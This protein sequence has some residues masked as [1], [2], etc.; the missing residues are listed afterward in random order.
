MDLPS[1]FSQVLGNGDCAVDLPPTPMMADTWK[2]V[3]RVLSM[4][5][6]AK[7]VFNECPSFSE[8][9]YF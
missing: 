2:M 7:G 3:C 1:A 9:F 4:G 8:F 5:Y 6:S